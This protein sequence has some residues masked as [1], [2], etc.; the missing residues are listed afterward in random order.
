MA[1]SYPFLNSLMMSF[2][3]NNPGWSIAMTKPSQSP[4]LRARLLKAPAVFLGNTAFW[5]VL[6]WNALIVNPAMGEE[7]QAPTVPGAEPQLLYILD[8]G[9]MSIADQRPGAA[10]PAQMQVYLSMIGS[11]METY[12]AVADPSLVLMAAIAQDAVEGAAAPASAAGNDGAPIMQ[13]AAAFRGEEGIMPRSYM[14]ED[15]YW[16]FPRLPDQDERDVLYGTKWRVVED[17]ESQMLFLG[18]D[19]QFGWDDFADIV[20]PLQHIPL[21]SVAYRALTGD[22][23]YGAA[24][25]FD[26]GF[27]P[28]AGMSTIADLAITS[29]TGSSMEDTAMAAIFGGGDETDNL[30]SLD[31]AEGQQLAFRPRRGSNQ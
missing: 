14:T 3:G 4:S 15:G 30:A 5:V 1:V 11:P 20:N 2:R 10:D 17:P 26:V 18:P 24:R 6:A 7:T 27:G 12:A 8:A 29:T 23:I 28:V 16:A 31:P 25:L 21:V 22:E 13:T 9:Q 19:R